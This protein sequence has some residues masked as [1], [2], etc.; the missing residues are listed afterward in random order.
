ME[1][2]SELMVIRASVGLI[3]AVQPTVRAQPAQRLPKLPRGPP[4]CHRRGAPPGV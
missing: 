2:H 4:G 3:R 1:D